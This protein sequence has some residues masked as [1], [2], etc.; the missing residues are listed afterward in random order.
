M[1]QQKSLISLRIVSPSWVVKALLQDKLPFCGIYIQGARSFRSPAGSRSR[2][3][4]E[5]GQQTA[6]AKGHI[7]RVSDFVGA[8]VA[9]APLSLKRGS[10][11][12]PYMNARV[13]PW[14]AE[15]LFR[16]MATFA[17]QGH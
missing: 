3:S 1:L 16:R 17:P 8:R 13:W 15:A 6:S 11:H 4:P 7:I 9:S 12:R 14:A 10:G 5:M 2:D